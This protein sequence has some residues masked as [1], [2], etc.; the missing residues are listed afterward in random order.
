MYA[1]AAAPFFALFFVFLLFAKLHTFCLFVFWM[2]VIIL[3][4]SHVGY[5]F[6]NMDIRK[7][8]LNNDL[9]WC[10]SMETPIQPIVSR[11]DFPHV[12][13]E[14]KEENHLTAEEVNSLYVTCDPENVFSFG[15]KRF[16]AV[17]DW[18]SLQHKGNMP[19]SGWYP[20]MVASYFLEKCNQLFQGE[21][22]YTQWFTTIYCPQPGCL[23][24]T[25]IINK[26]KALLEDYEGKPKQTNPKIR[27]QRALDDQM[28]EEKKRRIPKRS[29]LSASMA[30]EKE[31]SPYVSELWN[32]DICE[33]DNF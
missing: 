31:T 21:E 9:S 7:A 17:Y 25:H 6:P 19:P 27:I 14:T 26:K 22:G 30:I 4:V 28:E 15:P 23:N 18:I 16:I 32:P 2:I 8:S 29:S 11:L 5:H 13:F 1:M 24:R 12:S 3:T 33:E 10:T 20:F